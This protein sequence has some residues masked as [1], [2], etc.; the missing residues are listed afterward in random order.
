MDKIKLELIR[1][2]AGS[3]DSH[4]LEA[5][6]QRMTELVYEKDSDT[7]VIGFTAT[8]QDVIKSRFVQG[9]VQ[10]E[11]GI[12][13]GEYLTLQELERLSENW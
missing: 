11:M 5:L 4:M 1:W 10:A 9:I 12:R 3:E 13:N 6:H 7:K 8:G 2:I